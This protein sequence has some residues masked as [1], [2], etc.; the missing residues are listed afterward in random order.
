MRPAAALAALLLLAAAAPAGAEGRVR[1]RR[2]VDDEGV[3]HIEV[4]IGPSGESRRKA[5][6]V[7]VKPRSTGARA[8]VRDKTEWDEHIVQAAEKYRIPHELVRAI[9]VAESNFDPQA[10]SRVGARGLMQL[11][12]AT[13][14]EMFV[15]DSH[16]PIQNIYGGTRYLRVLANTF[17][18]D[19][20]RT[21]AAYNAGPNAVRKAGGIPRFAETQDYVRKVVK[22]YRIYKGLD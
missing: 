6:K 5:A 14:A 15:D 12:P 18:G 7:Q 16:D 20:I 2:W 3:L 8:R 21:V 1:E 9:I 19:I 13:A 10:V 17:G 22:L 11:M 4:K